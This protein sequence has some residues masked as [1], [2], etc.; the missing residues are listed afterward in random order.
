MMRA[1]LS[2]EVLDAAS[3]GAGQTSQ[4]AWTTVGMP[5]C[6]QAALYEALLIPPQRTGRV[7]EGFGHVVL[8][9]PT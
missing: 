3:S 7:T 9:S 4:A 2:L 5:Q 6:S 8:I 1:A